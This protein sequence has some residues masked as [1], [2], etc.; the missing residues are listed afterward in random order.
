ME[1]ESI[2][3]LFLPTKLQLKWAEGIK[4]MVEWS[5]ALPNRSSNKI[6]KVYE[7]CHTVLQ[8][9]KSKNISNFLE[10]FPNEVSLAQELIKKIKEK[11]NY[12]NELKILL[13]PYKIMF[14]SDPNRND[15][16]WQQKFNQS[17]LDLNKNTSATTAVIAASLIPY[18][19]HQLKSGATL[20]I[21]SKLPNSNND[22]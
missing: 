9:L 12:I 15:P 21:K 5:Q 10:T 22:E 4:Q 13:A 7:Q 20:N 2:E 6:I 19:I 17:F 3:P 1:V 18:K 14:P 8:N 11:S 16:Q